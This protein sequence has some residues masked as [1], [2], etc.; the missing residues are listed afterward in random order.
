MPGP[1]VFRHSFEIRYLDG[2]WQGRLSLLALQGY[3]QESAVLHCDSVGMTRAFLLE[4]GL[5]WIL[6]R[7]H[8]RVDHYPGFKEEVTVEPWPVN[9]GGLFNLRE[10]RVLN[11]QGDVCAVAT[12]RWILIDVNR[13]RPIRVP[14]MITSMF[15]V[16]EERVIDDPFDRMTD[17]TDP[18]LQKEFH[19][20]LSDLDINQH[21]NNASYLDWFL[22]TVPS[23]VLSTHVPSSI[24]IDF[25]R[26]ATLGAALHVAT[27]EQPPAPDGAREFRHAL[28]LPSDNQLLAQGRSSWRP[29]T[30]HTPTGGRS[31]R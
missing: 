22:E 4:N 23:D 5:T 25:K 9:V 6:N 18:D 15:E 21:A 17:V 1:P 24:E 3:L 20:R 29:D 14:E 30:A 11:P 28:R 16:H 10:F 19:V 13:K 26:E 27:A 7:I 31:S 12:S 8:I 2:D